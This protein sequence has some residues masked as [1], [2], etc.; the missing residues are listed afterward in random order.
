LLAYRQAQEIK[1]GADKKLKGWIKV[2]ARKI[3]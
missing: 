2:L 1:G 3:S